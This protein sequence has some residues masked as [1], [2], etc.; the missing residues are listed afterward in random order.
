[1]TGEANIHGR[2]R[3]KGGKMKRTLYPGDETI[4]FEPGLDWKAGELIALTGT[5]VNPET[6]ETLE[7]KS[8]DPASGVV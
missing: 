6:A 4:T 8:Y 5:S 7:I 3:D 1:M 2:P